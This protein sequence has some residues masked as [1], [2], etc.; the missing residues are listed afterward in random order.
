MS[1][2]EA[3]GRSKDQMTVGSESAQTEQLI[4]ADCVA[5]GQRSGGDHRGV[6]RR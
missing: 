2:A 5:G 3:N 1:N 6:V 4:G